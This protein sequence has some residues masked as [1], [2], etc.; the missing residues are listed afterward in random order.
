MG[1]PFPWI[2]WWPAAT[3][4]SVS[5]KFTNFQY[6]LYWILILVFTTWGML[7]IAN[8]KILREGTA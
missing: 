4:E 2:L 7:K 8:Q 1:T 6:A 3:A 5:I